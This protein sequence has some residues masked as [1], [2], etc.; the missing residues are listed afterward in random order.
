MEDGDWALD[1]DRASK[2]DGDW[3]ER[4]LLGL[5]CPPQSCV[6]GGVLRCT[7]SEKQAANALSHEN[8]RGAHG[9]SAWHL[10]FFA[11][12]LETMTTHG[13]R[14]QVLTGDGG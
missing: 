14:A 12:F 1:D 8:P 5:S 2:Y 7:G 13:G 3:A 10:P 6:C 9:N 4:F 11:K